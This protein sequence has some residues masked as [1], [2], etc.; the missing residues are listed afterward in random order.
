[1]TIGSASLLDRIQR[2]EVIALQRDLVRVPSYT[3]EEASLARVIF[4]HMRRIGLRARLDPVALGDGQESFNVVGQ[5]P[6]PSTS[7]SLLLIGHMDHAPALGRAFDD[8]SLWSR[9]PFDGTVEG[10]WFYGK[11]AQDEKGGLCAMLM[12]AKALIEEGFKPAASVY[13]VAVQGHKRVSS[14]TRQL[15]GSGFRTTYAINTENSGNTI[16]P[17]WVGRAE[18]R[19]HVRARAGGRE[20]HFHFKEIDPV[21]RDR[22]SVFEQTARLLSALGPEMAPPERTRWFT[23][24]PTDRL[25]GYPQYRIEKVETRSQMHVVV[26]FQIRT[27]PGQSEET[28]R[29]DLLS[30]LDRLRTTDPTTDM[31]LEFPTAPVRP[32]VDIPHDHPLVRT[33]A[34]AHETI[35]GHQPEVSSR[36]RLG[37]AADASLIAAV[38]ITTVLYGPG[39]GDSDAEHQR[40]VH[41]GRVPTDERISISSIID[42]AKVFALTAMRL[43]G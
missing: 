34:S 26:S 31:E 4:A 33:L 28:L 42:A 23:C 39:G 14:G 6:G 17:S 32:A 37:A 3:T 41:E 29:R 22:L 24:T 36:G 1:M 19:V 15:L 21:V 43:C 2:D 18:G 7:S 9:N 25:P 5:I 27:I 13:F 38:G 20:L 11:G 8:L 10:D 35:T 40:A 30:V 12:A 16:V